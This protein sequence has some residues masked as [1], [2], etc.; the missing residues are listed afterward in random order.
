MKIQLSSIKSD[1]R[2]ICKNVNDT[3]FFTYFL[4]KKFFFTKI[5][6]TLTCNIFILVIFQ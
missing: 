3:T 2:D 1:I 5:L 4:W 6:L